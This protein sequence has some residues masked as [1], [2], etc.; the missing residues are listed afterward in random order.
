MFLTRLHEVAPPPV[1]PVVLHRRHRRR[2]KTTQ[3]GTV[4]I[5]LGI[6][7]AFVWWYFGPGTGAV[8]SGRTSN[9]PAINANRNKNVNASPVRTSSADADSDGLSDELETV[10]GTEAQKA[11]S[12]G[13][14]FQD[15]LEVENGYDPLNV[16]KSARMV[17]LGLV[18]TVAKGDPETSV[19]SSG[20]STADRAR[21]YLLFDGASTTYYSADGTVNAQCQ[22]N[23][24]PQGACRTLPNQ[25]RTDFSRT[26]DGDSFVDVYHIPF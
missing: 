14:G 2:R 18:S 12:D 9:S 17:D 26:Y 23:V 20:M 10:Y 6:A 13:D 11:D 22:L 7:G 1:D 15:G 4:V 24:E 16:G 19:V 8:Q 21:Y 25:V 5:V 3:W